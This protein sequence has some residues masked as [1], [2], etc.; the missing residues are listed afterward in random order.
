MEL[1]TQTNID[2]TT[3]MSSEITID[4][5]QENDFTTYTFTVQNEHGSKTS[6]VKMTKGNQ[7]QFLTVPPDDFK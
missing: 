4:S 5:L 6:D 2:D 1:S 7:L 3:W